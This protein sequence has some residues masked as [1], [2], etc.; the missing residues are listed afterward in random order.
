MAF[1]AAHK[2]IDQGDAPYRSSDN[3]VIQAMPAEWKV[4]LGH[5]TPLFVGDSGTVEKG[6][7]A[8]VSVGYAGVGRATGKIVTQFL[9]GNTMVKPVT[10]KGDDL[11]LNAITAK[12]IGMEITPELLK[13]ATK[14]YR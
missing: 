7:L 11:Y 3:P 4:C 5:K 8:T 12:K 10:A 6:G 14:V 13:R 2:A 9:R 1:D